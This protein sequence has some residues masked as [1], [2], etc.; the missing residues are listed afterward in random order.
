MTPKSADLQCLNK[1]TL[2]GINWL[3][4]ENCFLKKKDVLNIIYLRHLCGLKKKQQ[5]T[6]KFYFFYFSNEKFSIE[7][8]FPNPI[9]LRSNSYVYIDW[10]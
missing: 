9:I 8:N 6:W 4:C 3:T 2:I 7:N 10:K 1:N 5:K